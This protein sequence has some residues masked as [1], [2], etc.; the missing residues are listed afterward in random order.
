MI[1]T[2]NCAN[3]LE[4]TLR[5]VLEQAPKADVMQ[6]EVVDDCSTKDDPEAVVRD[7][8]RGRVSFYR[9]PQNVGPIRNFNTCVARSVGQIVHILHGDDVVLPGFYKALQEAFDKEPLLGAAF[10]RYIFVDEKDN[11]VLLSAHESHSAGV[12]ESFLERI[13]VS[14]IIQTPSIVVKRSVYENLGG[15]CLELFHAGD[16]EMWKRI[17]AYYP[18]WYEPQPLACY[19]MH[20]ASHSS[21]LVKSGANIANIRQSIELSQLYLP[22]TMAAELTI[23]AREYYALTAFKTA[24]RQLIK[25]DIITALAQ[26]REAFKCSYSSGVIKQMVRFLIKVEIQRSRQALS[27]SLGL[28]KYLM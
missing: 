28:L 8:G 12:L 18:V 3:Y 13:A 10:C 22:D 6:I 19:R 7:V 21:S 5:S 27:K 9:Q 15:Y 2:Y 17:G 4:R 20:P 24:Y 23:R 14:C 26:A 11:H 25:S 1:P 16:W